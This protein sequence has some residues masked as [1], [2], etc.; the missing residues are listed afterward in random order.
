[1]KIRR[2]HDLALIRAIFT[3]PT[4]Y[5]AAGD[6]SAPRAEDFEPNA[7]ERIY[8]LEIRSDDGL[9]AG[10]ITLVPENCASYQIH[11]AVLPSAWG[12]AAEYLRG[13][14]AWSWQHTPA[15]RIVARIPEYNRLALALARRAGLEQYG[16]NERSFLKRGRLWDTV[17][18]GI[19]PRI[20]R[21]PH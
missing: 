3:H 16:R 19:S 6:D 8:Y 9:I 2:T 12:K 10:V 1:M 5:D 11:I 7:D 18:F 17:D 15:R 14:I 13:A 4:Q 20:E 21:K